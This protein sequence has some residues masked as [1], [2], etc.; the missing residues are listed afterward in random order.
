MKKIIKV[1][2]GATLCG[3]CLSMMLILVFHTTDAD[4]NEGMLEIVG[5]D[6][7]GLWTDNS[8]AGFDTY[9]EEAAKQFP[10]ISYKTAAALGVGVYE[11]DMVVTA[12]DHMGN[13]V[14]VKV[15]SMALPDG[16]EITGLDEVSQLTFQMPGIYVLKLKARD[17]WNRES[18]KE[19]EIPVN[20]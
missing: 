3:I 12:H 15:S 20:G 11:L 2:G 19:V 7:E 1:L 18:V 10:E 9:E 13:P 5:A 17:S 8:T 16:T 6:F 14:R 4:E